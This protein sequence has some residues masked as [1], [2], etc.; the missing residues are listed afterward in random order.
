MN[1]DSDFNLIKLYGITMQLFHSWRHQCRSKLLFASQ[2][3]SSHVQV[4]AMKTDKAIS[5]KQT[6]YARKEFCITFI[7]TF[8]FLTRSLHTTGVNCQG[9]T[10]TS[11]DKWSTLLGP[12]QHR[13]FLNHLFTLPW[14]SVTISYKCFTTPFSYIL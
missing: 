5:G 6:S 4:C 3:I 11:L 2:H 14:R 10:E 8:P 1:Y 12:L 7:K 13:S 9:K